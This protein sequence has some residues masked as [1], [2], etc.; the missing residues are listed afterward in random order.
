MYVQLCRLRCKNVLKKCGFVRFYQSD[1]VFGY[2]KPS[3]TTFNISEKWLENRQKSSN[4]YRLVTAYRQH[5][6]KLANVDP[7][8]LL[9]DISHNEGTELN[10]A[11]YGFTDPSE[12]IDLPAGIVNMP[13]D[14]VSIS[15]LVEFLSQ[16]YCNY[17]SIEYQYIENEEEREWLSQE[18]E[19]LSTQE[20]EKNVKI[21]LAKEL[22]RSEEFDHFMAKKFASV[23]RYGGEGAESMMGFFREIFE[24]AAKDTLQHIVL[25]MPHRGR[26][27]LLTGLLN[28]PPA[29]IF[30]KLRGNPDFP[31]DY[32]CSGDVL[33]HIISST[34]LS[35]EDSKSVH[36]S[37]LYNPSHLEAVNPVSMGKTRAK[38]L[39]VKDGA[40]NIS[41][42]LSD[43]V[44]NIQVHGDAALIGQGVNQESLE[45]MT[46]PHF[47]VGGTVHFVVNNQLGFTTPGQRGRSSRYCTDL[48]KIVEA[49]VVHVNGDHPEAVL[50][51]TRLAFNYQRRFRKDVFIDMNCFRRWGH[52][53]MDDPTFTN[54]ATYAI[55]HQK[56]SVPDSY[57]QQLIDEGIL[58][59]QQCQDIRGEHFD[60]LNEELGQSENWLPKD[61]YFKSQ[62]T[63]FGQAPAAVTVWDTG[64]DVDL[65]T[66]IGE[67]SVKYPESF[68]IHPTVQR[69]HVKNRL[70]RIGE[71]L[72]VDWSTAE[73]LAI[74]SLLFEGYNVR[75]SGQDV[76]RGTFSQRHAML[77]D[78]DSNSIYIPLN[79]LHGE[80][81]GFLEVANSILSEEAVLG[82]EYGMSIENPNNLIVWEAQ[83]GDFFNGAQI[84]FDTFISTGEAKW[85]YQSGLTVLLPHG[86]DGAGP[87]HS[88]S[89]LERFLQMT[90]SKEDGVDGDDV[91]MQVCQ[92][93]T[94]AQYFH[95]LR[96]QMVRNYRKPLIVITPKTLLRAP[97]CVSTFGDMTKG[98]HFR[99]VLGDPIV[100]PLRAKRVL[101]TSGK[102][103]YSLVRERQTIGANDAAIVRVES[104]CP[105]PTQELT[106]ELS[107]YKNAKKFIWCQ[108][109]PQNMGAWTFFK[110]RFEN[111]VGKPVMYCGRPT[112]AAPAAGVAKLHKQQETEILTKP[113]V[114]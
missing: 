81:K 47:E 52:N 5:G 76:G 72:K 64:I 10:I 24:L 77:V 92:P 57:S 21:T 33:S 29:Q 42:N 87:E 43:K 31:D 108:E 94:P 113:F 20:L 101:L 13:K 36:V 71:G 18:Y 8:S 15:E 19:H 74:G 11:R 99:P 58:T 60:W 39:G 114:L 34:N 41:S 95:L 30:N 100:D 70:A 111:L 59:H 85:I 50:K 65:M 27:N 9:D 96:R 62:W 66:F 22:L 37:V 1:N 89:K 12:Q 105:F 90:D 107:N 38:Q 112:A 98:S 54:P 32:V 110:R 49:P 26:L 35:Y 14:K 63:G 73:A 44:L 78:Q 79:H 102:H 46:T 69:G 56:R 4:L 106:Q 80:Q 104:F 3:K 75:I 7:I 2:K 28:Y 97:E 61:V 55:I 84:I 68:K 53:E 45:L 93:S 48:A 88:S 109:E 25:A 83:F 17:T 86:Y 6:H 23:K 82:F 40:Y 103:F 51:A 91:N 67:K 16:T